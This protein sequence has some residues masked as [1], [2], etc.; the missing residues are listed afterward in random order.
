VF[1][2]V[3]AEANPN[4]GKNLH[5]VMGDIVQEGEGDSARYFIEWR[6]S[7]TAAGEFTLHSAGVWYNHQGAT[8]TAKAFDSVQA[9]LGKWL[10]TLATWLF[11]LSTMI[12]WSY[13]GEQGVVYLFGDK[14]VFPYKIIYCLLIVIASIP[15]LI[16]TDA[17]L[18]NL[19]ALGTGVMLWAN[20]PIML[21]F[22]T[23]AMRA[24]H[25]YFRRMKSGEME[26]P[27]KA[28]KVTD[29]VEG[30]DVE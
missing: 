14:L 5:R 18:D 27:H 6:T 17:Q 8:L 22:G 9:G 11:A 23:V 28:P 3:E 24:Y 7:P 20:I 1:A 15:T 30:H 10:V 26:G 21:I 13:Y 2:I 19:T 4:T 12:S 29:V 16:A 25:D